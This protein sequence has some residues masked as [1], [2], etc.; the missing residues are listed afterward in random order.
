V[1]LDPLAHYLKQMNIDWDIE[2]YKNQQS[3]Y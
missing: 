1:G 3:E 2:E